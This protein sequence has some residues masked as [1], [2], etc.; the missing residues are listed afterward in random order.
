MIIGPIFTR[1]AVTLPRRPRFFVLRTV[2]VTGL[3]I[4]MAT[5]WAVLAGTQWIRNVGDMARFGAMV[6]QILAPLQL[7]L[8]LFFAAL[9]GAS[10]VAQEKDRRTLVLLLMTRLTNHE[11]V[12]GKL[13]AGLLS[14]A[15]M[16]A[17]AVPL[18]LAIT[19]FGGVSYAQVGRVFCVTILA[20]LLAGSW[21]CCVAFARDKTFQTLALTAL[22][23]LV[24]LGVG[25]LAYWDVGGWSARIGVESSTVAAS[26]SPVRAVLAAARPVPETGTWSDWANGIV[27]FT[28]VAVMVVVL[29][30]GYAILRVR[31]WNPSR[32]VRRGERA[33]EEGA[34]IFVAGVEAE[35]SAEAEIER[36]RMQHIDARRASGPV[37][38]REVWDNP[39]LWREVCTW[40]YGRKVVIIRIVYCLLFAAV[41]V[42]LRAMTS[43][44]ALTKSAWAGL[45]PRTALV[46]APF[47]LI[48]LVVRNALAVTA[49]TNERDGQS[50][51]LLLATDL[52]PQEFVLGKLF[53]V[54]W[55]T[56]E[57]LLLP[58]VAIGYLWWRG[59]VDVE[60]AVFLAVGWIVLDLFATML[61]L[62]I[63]MTYASSR[64]AIGLSLGT[65]FFLF[66][67]VVTCMAMMISFSGS[68]Q[69]QLAPFLAFILGGSVGLYYA[70][71]FRNP[72]TAI[73]VA[74]LL[75][76]WMTFHAITSFLL[77]RS[78]SAFTVTCGTYGFA[79]AALL[80]PAISEFDIA[81]GRT[82]ANE[83]E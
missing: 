64:A 16:V 35:A 46:L 79:T 75:L 42:A 11:L 34:S 27:G 37:P 71:G 54:M 1:E 66:L 22:G 3:L 77:G 25:E 43:D 56:R 8:V 23:L 40:A 68:F 61:G 19:L 49:I 48:S 29:I 57:T 5:S 6:F 18:F 45:V 24:W 72:S 58:L 31:V 78:L 2:Y 12:L 10:V 36:R 13:C 4:L 65:V 17:S 9:M 33:E 30:N 80:V 32:E 59:G 44:E 55:V 14:L 53:G 81:M 41:I 47:F 26:I 20:G 28:L 74:S 52:T 83:G 63:G 76:P 70:L 67:G 69:S 82:R 39:V 51:D 21:G 15:V 60:G 7:A 62:H 50:L 73:L 38:S